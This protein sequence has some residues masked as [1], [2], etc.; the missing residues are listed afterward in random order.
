MSR[1]PRVTV[2]RVLTVVAGVTLLA[3]P[4]YRWFFYAPDIEVVEAVD[5]VV[6]RGIHG[7]G[8]VQARFPVAV[9]ARITAAVVQ[10]H[11]DQG[12]TVEKGQL[13][14][15]LDDRDLAARAALARTELALSRANYQRDLE[16]FDQG[17]ISQAAMDATT[18][19]LRAAEARGQEADAALSHSSIYAPVGGVITAREV[20]VGHTL[21][22]GGTLFRLVDPGTL[23]VVA[24]VDEAVVGLVTLGQPATIEL[25]TGAVAAGRVARIGLESDAATRELDVGVAFDVPPERFAVNQEA[26][27]TIHAGDARGVVIPSSAVLQQER[28]LG[29]LVVTEGRTAFRP[30]TTGTT[31]GDRVVVSTGLEFGEQVVRRPFGVKVGRRVLAV[32]GGAR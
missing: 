26:E 6:A 19:A 4:A 2:G 8:T 22:P 21:S 3:L 18:A 5:G 24:R 15:R 31:D 14:A 28:T 7:P 27:V 13:L 25:R 30:V 32:T 29:V 12:D 16:V 1:A 20:E 10:L 17:Y 23:W 11:A 9:S